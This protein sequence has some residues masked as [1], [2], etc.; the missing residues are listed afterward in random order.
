MLK[1]KKIRSQE[2]PKEPEKVIYFEDFK[3]LAKL[4]KYKN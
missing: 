2:E 3:K 4:E 1:T